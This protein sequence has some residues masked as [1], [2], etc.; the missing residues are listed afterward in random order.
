MD[1][2]L[3]PVGRCGGEIEA[4]ASKSHV[5]RLLIAAALSNQNCIEYYFRGYAGN[6]RLSECTR[7]EY[8]H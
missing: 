7:C 5:H 6:H 8:Y 3:L 2:K 1:R 4:I